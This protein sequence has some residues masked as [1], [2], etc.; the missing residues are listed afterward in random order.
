LS[1]QNELVNRTLIYTLYSY[2]KQQH[3]QNRFGLGSDFGLRLGLGSDVGWKYFCFQ[4]KL[5]KSFF[6]KKNFGVGDVG[7]CWVDPSQTVGR[8]VGWSPQGP[9]AAVKTKMGEPIPKHLKVFLEGGKEEGGE[10]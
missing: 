4:K 6:S 5:G 10:G 7:D 9:P 3:L 2:N 8:F 1:K